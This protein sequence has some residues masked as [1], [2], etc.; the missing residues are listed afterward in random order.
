M[1]NSKTVIKSM[2]ID[3]YVKDWFFSLPKTLAYVFFTIIFPLM[4]KKPINAN[5]AKNANKGFNTWPR[6]SSFG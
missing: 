6:I 1:E 4:P 3:E 2:Y 5:K